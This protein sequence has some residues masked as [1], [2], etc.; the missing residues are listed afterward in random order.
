MLL[1]YL[2][3][4]LVLVGFITAFPMVMMVYPGETACWFNFVL[5]TGIDVVLGLFLYF[6][7]L[8]KRKR[9]KFVRHQ[10]AM[11]LVLVWLTAILSG[12]APM[13]IA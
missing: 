1:G 2:G 11:L 4:F 13:F 6:V 3:I 9:T 12:A 10:D 8:F 5:P 7:F